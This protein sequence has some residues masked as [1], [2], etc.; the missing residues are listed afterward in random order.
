[1]TYLPAELW[2]PEPTID[3]A[4]FWEGARQHEIRFQR[5]SDCGRFRHHPTP[6]CARCGSLK[7]EWVKAGDDA[8][9]FSFTI[10]H[11]AADERV[12]A[13]LP[14]NVA[15]VRF[16]S[17]GDVRLVSNVVGTPSDR[18]E[19]GMKLKPVWEDTAG[20]IPVPRFEVA[21]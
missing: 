4:G 10:V 11:Y 16:P 19:I 7:S 18:L 12:K 13:H 21:G 9:L 17:C 20:G 2:S 14:Y 8:E 1:M 15:I 5:C 6:G 3:D